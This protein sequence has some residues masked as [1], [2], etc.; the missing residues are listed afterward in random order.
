MLRRLRTAASASF[1]VV[2]LSL[3]VL[4]AQGNRNAFAIRGKLP[5]PYD[6]SIQ[7]LHGGMSINF[8]RANALWAME[9]SAADLM[10]TEDGFQIQQP[11]SFFHAMIRPGAASFHAPIWILALAGGAL[12][13][14]LSP[15]LSLR[16]SLR[17]LLIL[18]TVVAVVLW[19]VAFGITQ[20]KLE[21]EWRN[22]YVID[23]Q[24]K[25]WNCRKSQEDI[26]H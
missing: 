13:A 3:C 26:L 6:F 18:M 16:F 14:S 2:C 22:N 4:W 23:Q 1:A 15:P 5:G 9:Y 20:K 19:L 11:K 8:F 12:A 21:N 24:I 25:F 17:T 10:A 7:T